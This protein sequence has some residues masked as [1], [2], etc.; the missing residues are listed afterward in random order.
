MTIIQVEHNPDKDKLTAL[1]VKSWPVWNCEVS[2][3]PWPYDTKE[4][5]YLLGGEVVVVTPDSG[6]PVT[7][8]AGALVVFPAGMSCRWNVLKTVRNHYKFD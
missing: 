8:T 2:E 5:C 4:T 6:K 1:G 7:I 3:F